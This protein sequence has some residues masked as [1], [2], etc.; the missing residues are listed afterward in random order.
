[1][2]FSALV[3]TLTLSGAAA[4]APS[5]SR[6][7]SNVAMFSSPIEAATEA[8]NGTPE[9]SSAAEPAVAE[10]AA[11]SVPVDLPVDPAAEEKKVEVPVA[12]EEPKD[13]I[14]PG[15]YPE[16]CMSIALPMLKRP[17]KLDGTHAGDFGFD[18]LGLSEQFDLYTMQEAEVR[19]ARLAMLAVIGWPMAELLGPKWLLQPG[20]CA[21]SVL[22]GFSPITFIATVAV[23]GGIG[24]LEY[25]TSLRS[26][27]VTKL[28]KQHRSDMSEV[29]DLGVAGDYDFDPLEL[30]KSVGDDA[31]ARKGLREVEISHG[32][33][34]MLGITAFAAWEA[35][36]GHAIVEN[37]MFFHPNLLLPALVAGYT[38]FN[39]VYKVE[40]SDQYILQ[41]SKSSEGDALLQNLALGMPTEKDRQETAAKISAAIDGAKDLAN[42]ATESYNK[43]ADGYLEY[44][45]GI[46]KKDE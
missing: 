34:A 36:T 23:F 20:G 42:K 28:G 3:L 11:A 33:S 30:Y 14:M 18:P 16:G 7:P 1:M 2:K 9:E 17:N 21:P 8:V 41:I 26:Q 43:L 35:L 31:K 15:R 44:S 40:N 13:V 6:I 39:A 24:Y 46:E 10:P 32:R 5:A 37:S 19:H 25:K 22:N 4:F 38:F 29:W 12:A 45:T 27:L